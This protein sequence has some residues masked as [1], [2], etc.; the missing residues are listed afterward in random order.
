GSR[1]VWILPQL[2]VGRV[3]RENPAAEPSRRA[4]RRGRHGAE[5]DRDPMLGLRAE[6]EIRE[7]PAPARESDP[8]LVPGLAEHL[9]PFFHQ[10]GPAAELDSDCF[11]LQLYIACADA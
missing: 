8:T 11:E 9:L 5:V 3:A 2:G 7:L 10:R 1:A 4:Q 6:R